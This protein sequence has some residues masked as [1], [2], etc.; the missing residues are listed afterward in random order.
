M[1][2]RAPVNPPTETKASVV[3]PQV[4]VLEPEVNVIPIGKKKTQVYFVYNGHEWESHEVL[5][6]EPGVDLAE[7]TAA[8][9]YLIKTADSSAFEFFESAYTAI[10]K[11]RGR[12]EF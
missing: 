11:K 10:L 1:N 6:I 2:L 4:E 7:A 3:K 5:G 12:R 9:Q 8:Y